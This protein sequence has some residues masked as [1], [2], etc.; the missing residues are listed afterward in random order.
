LIGSRSPSASASF[1]EDAAGAGLAGAGSSNI[2]DELD[3]ETVRAPGSPAFVRAAAP[4]GLR[5]L[6]GGFIAAAAGSG[7]FDV[8]RVVRTRGFG[9]SGGCAL[10]WRDRVVRTG[11]LAI[12]LSV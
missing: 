2:V 11:R 7:A 3:C 10:G 6:D 5:A 9:S 4:G 1:E 8:A 12:A